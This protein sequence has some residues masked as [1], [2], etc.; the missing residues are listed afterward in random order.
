MN[1][2]IPAISTTET[3]VLQYEDAKGAEVL[4]TIQR[5]IA[6]GWK[7]WMLDSGSDNFGTKLDHFKKKSLTSLDDWRRKLAAS[8]KESEEAENKVRRANDRMNQMR[9]AYFRDLSNLR[10][11]LQIKKKL[12]DQG[13][14]HAF[15]PDMIMNFDPADYLVEDDVRKVVEEKVQLCF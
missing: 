2:Q 5:T 14:G 9:D 10:E 15:K 13:N 12:E 11:Q 3:V 6:E 4:E 7:E 1:I 8:A